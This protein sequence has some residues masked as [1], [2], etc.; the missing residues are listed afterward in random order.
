MRGYYGTK[1]ALEESSEEFIYLQNLR[2]R[3]EEKNMYLEIRDQKHLMLAEGSTDKEPSKNEIIKAIK[4]RG[5]DVFNIS[6]IYDNMIG[7]WRF[8]ADIKKIN[9][10]RS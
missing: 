3:Y 8:N 5:Y 9:N 7:L 10:I 2:K 4:N 1:L 6:I